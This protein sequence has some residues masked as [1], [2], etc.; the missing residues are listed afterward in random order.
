VWRKL[1]ALRR[2]STPNQCEF[3][4]QQATAIAP[5]PR[6][7]LPEGELVSYR[8][9]L[10]AATARNRGIFLMHLA[11]MHLAGIAEHSALSSVRVRQIITQA[12]KRQ[13]RLRER[14]R[15]VKPTCGIFA[16][17][18]GETRVSTPA[19]VYREIE[20]ERAA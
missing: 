20:Q 14:W 13:G 3:S 17:R 10:A 4:D 19:D 9:R 12:E 1:D 7:P 16:D 18:Y 6:L 15:P 11:G 2:A 5:K 8:Q